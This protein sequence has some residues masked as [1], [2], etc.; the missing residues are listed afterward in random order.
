MIDQVP[1]AS[2]HTL[3]SEPESCFGRGE[4]TK[5]GGL[6]GEGGKEGVGRVWVQPTFPS[7]RRRDMTSQHNHLRIPK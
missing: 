1:G 6:S 7:G 4:K 5:K 2:K 3:K